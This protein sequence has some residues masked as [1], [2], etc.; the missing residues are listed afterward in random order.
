MTDKIRIKTC[1]TCGSDKIRYIIR[2]I[3]R[4]YKDRTYTVP[5]VGF[6]ACPNCGEKVYDREAMKK[7]E[8]HSPAY[9]KV[10]E[11]IEA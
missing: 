9:H 5:R 4:Q 11:L 2:D 7:I 6:Y 10:E 3:T 8:A 1:P